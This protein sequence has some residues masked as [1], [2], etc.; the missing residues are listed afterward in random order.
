MASVTATVP[1]IVP[2]SSPATI[3]LLGQGAPPIVLPITNPS[4]TYANLEGNWTEVTRPGLKPLNVKV[5][6]KLHTVAITST[7]V[8]AD[9]GPRDPGNSV[10]PILAAL[11]G[12]ANGDGT[13]PV[14]FTWGSLDS[15]TVMTETG[16]WRVDSLSIASVTRQPVTN[17][18]S[19]ATVTLT[20]KEVSDPVA[21]PNVQSTDPTSG[22]GSGTKP[23]ANVSSYIVKQGDTL[24]SIAQ[25][26]YGT[27]SDWVLLGYENNIDN[28]TDIYPGEKLTVDLPSS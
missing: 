17:N 26:I 9:S 7:I 2:P 22:T 5:G 25:Q 12:L 4:A 14:A 1:G 3:T 15:G 28:P 27:S 13:Y 21:N 16:H 18:M 23:A 6:L 11:I 10:E 24:Y 19:Q 20:L 8:G